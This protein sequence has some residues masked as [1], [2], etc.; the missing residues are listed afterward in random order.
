[1]RAMVVDDEEGIRLVLRRVL[2]QEGYEVMEAGDGCQAL[3]LLREEP[4]VVICD[5]RMPGMDGLET[6]RRVGQRCPGTVRVVLTGY[7]TLQD[8]I[9]A[10]NEGVDGFLTKPVELGQLRQ[11]IR[12]FLVRRLLRQMV[13]P[14]VL[15]RMW[16][17]PQELQPRRCRATVVFADI[18]GFSRL[19]EGMDPEG[20]LD[21]LGR[22][23]FGPALEAILAEGGTVDK[24]MGD[25]VMALFGAPLSRPDDPLRAARCALRLRGLEVPVGVGVATGEVIAGLL[26]SSRKREYSVLGAAVNR[27][28]RLQEQARAG[29]VLV[30]EET[31]RSLAGAAVGERVEGLRGV[32]A[33]WRLQRLDGG[34]G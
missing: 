24:I 3:Q 14:Q 34:T 11:A 16:H 19:A 18:R 4:D 20:L 23:F 22:R 33:A 15:E 17:D 10:T 21:F 2:E 8:A 31:W 6:L 5:L 1:M 30:D 25:G 29:E 28:A 12:Q 26:G 13:S 27:A 32:E 7:A 9:Q